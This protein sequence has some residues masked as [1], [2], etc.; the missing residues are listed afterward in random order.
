MSRLSLPIEHIKARYDVVVIGSGYGGAIAASRAARAGQSVCLL[1]R[2]KEFQ[3]GEYPD[4]LAEGVEELQMSTDDGHIGAPSGLYDLH[5]GRDISV[6]HGCGL[7]G[8]SL[9][10]AGV[11]LR[12]DPRVFDEPQWPAP[13]RADVTGALA[14][15]YRRAEDMLKP[16]PYPED[17]PALAKLHALEQSAKA[18]DAPFYRPPINVTFRDHINHVGVQQHACT[19][20]GDCVTGCNFG[21]K[22]TLI[23][24]YLPDAVHHGA[25]VFTEVLVEYLA[26]GDDRWLVFYQPTAVGR[27]SF[28]APSLFV[29]ADVVV[30]AGG[31]LGSTELLLRSKAK[32]LTL[33]DSVGRGFT[34]NGDF[35]AFACDTDRAIDGVGFGDQPPGELPPVGPC[36]SGI[37]DMRDRP[38]ALQGIVIEEGSIPGLLSLLLPD[39]LCV[40]EEAVGRPVAAHGPRSVPSAVA[41]LAEMLWHPRQHLLS[42]TQTY[43]VM[44]H[45]SDA[46]RMY[47]DGDHLR[48]DWPDVGGLPLF[49]AVNE[50]LEQATRPLGGSYVKDPLWSKALHNRLVTVHP[51]GG[52]IMA[53]RSEDGVVDHKC[54]VFCSDSGDA[55]H[56]G[57]YVCDAA[58]LPRPLGVNPLLTISAVAERC[59]ALM[60][61][62]RGW[63]VDVDAGRSGD[64][65]VQEPPT[66]VGIRFTERMRGYVSTSVLDDYASAARRG[67]ADRSPLE[68]TLTIASDDVEDM[69]S[70]R[71]HEA[72]MVGTVTAPVL[73]STPLDVVQGTFNLFLED[74]ADPDLRH[75]RYRMIL[76]SQTDRDYFFDGYKAMHGG[77]GLSMWSDTTTL[78]VD[79]HDGATAEAPVIARGILRITPRDFV[80]QLAS[81]EAPGAADRLE[82]I[83]A[84]AR[85]GRLFAGTLWD[86]YGFLGPSHRG[87][88][89]PKVVVG[90]GG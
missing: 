54:Q 67:R 43:L 55:V 47:L 56:D 24:N 40:A 26:R 85:F 64:G 44:G 28:S 17:F 68:F 15:G 80:R 75:M 45:D 70:N 66:A 87:G 42:H 3:P 33:S 78:Y 62:D 53:E 74:A 25:E 4:T 20:C 36:I 77:H 10:N 27:Q 69:I 8:T 84:C 72:G 34:G 79:I 39:M 51:L 18:L 57:L 90:H 81:L 19:L 41:H 7:G 65:A 89:P 71:Q 38:N 61:A 86:V 22:N 12:P 82:A 32:G 37:I 16:S 50:T 73:A 2:G 31:A 46:G 5:I 52:C 83:N 14:D 63:V 6:F 9:V 21:A 13:F 58:V 30:V 88:L 29:E 76:R 23:M 59:L 11:A 1:E 48:I 35:L 60:A 49:S